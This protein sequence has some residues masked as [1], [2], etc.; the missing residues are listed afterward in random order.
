[1]P[2]YV[3]EMP[4]PEPK[5]INRLKIEIT[6]KL[7]DLIDIIAKTDAT[8]TSFDVANVVAEAFK[9]N[10]QHILQWSSLDE[11]WYL[12]NKNTHG[13]EASRSD[14]KFR[15]KLS[16]EIAKLFDDRA[17]HW[18]QSESEESD[19]YSL[20]MRQA[21]LAMKMTAFKDNVI[22]E[23]KGLLYNDELAEL[24]DSN[25]SLIRFT[26]GV[27]DLKEHQFRDGMPKDYCAYSTNIEYKEYEKVIDSAEM[28]EI[29]DYLAKVFVDENMR[30]FMLQVLS[31][32]LD[33]FYRQERLYM[34]TGSGA[35]SKS[36]LTG[37]LQK[38]LGDYYC[39]LPIA[40]LTQKRA[41]SNSAQSELERTKG[42]R[43]AMSQ[44]PENGAVINVGLMKELTGG[45]RI[46][47]RGLFKEPVEF[48]PQ[49]KLFLACNDLPDITS[50]DGGTW[51]RIRVIEFKSKF[52][53]KPKENR[54]TEFAIDYQLSEKMEKWK[55]CFISY[56]IHIYKNLP[57]NEDG[58]R[59]IEEPKSV[60]DATNK[61]KR[62][63]DAIGSYIDECIKFKDA[64]DPEKSRLSIASIHRNFKSWSR[65]ANIKNANNIT[66]PVLEKQFVVKMRELYGETLSEKDIYSR[67]VLKEE[68]EYDSE[69]EDVDIDIHFK[70]WFSGVF[71]K[72][73][74][75]NYKILTEKVID[76]YLSHYTLE[77]YRQLKGCKVTSDL[78]AKTLKELTENMGIEKKLMGHNR[79]M[80]LIGIRCSDE[81][82][83]YLGTDVL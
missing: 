44:E 73:T 32:I 67:S 14:C 25:G 54:K 74:E 75:T 71:S 5:Q 1:M 18:K 36:I 2:R 59:F 7:N 40:L 72:D 16:D 57:I 69:N 15:N 78:L 51:R 13:W 3:P 9:I 81:F 76:V 58:K 63:N 70:H 6:D 79:R 82:R 19:R 64:D 27:Y 21:S 33:G 83:Q 34:L 20:R 55:E 77:H 53:E 24:M 39:I 68:G 17:N 22:K 8:P 23:M 29:N 50:D 80:G 43:M 4:L 35:N 10:G 45:D 46:Q 26:N 62:N 65:D 47:A 42:R 28:K 11:K 61:Y 41:S 31:T 37:F 12:F 60:I 52:V 66:R 30:K 49:F 38:C 48:R 56:L